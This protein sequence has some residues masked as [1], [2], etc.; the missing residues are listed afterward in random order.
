MSPAFGA[1]K[2]IYL[3]KNAK[4]AAIPL[5]FQNGEKTKPNFAQSYVLGATKTK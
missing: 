1:E 4:N 5:P 3:K 2:K